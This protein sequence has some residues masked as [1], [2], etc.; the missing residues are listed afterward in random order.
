MIRKLLRRESNNKNT[1]TRVEENIESVSDLEDNENDSDTTLEI[2]ISVPNLS[3]IKTGCTVPVTTRHV[4][5][6]QRSISDTQVR[7]NSKFISIQS[8][9]IEN[10]FC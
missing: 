10:S 2:S 6:L 7:N 1:D 3:D 9:I 4:V 8:N 5:Q